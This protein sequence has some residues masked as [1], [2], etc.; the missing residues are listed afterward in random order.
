[1]GFMGN[2]DLSG[3]RILVTKDT[4]LVDRGTA[5]MEVHGA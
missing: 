1:M 5:C 3:G 2:W 4:C